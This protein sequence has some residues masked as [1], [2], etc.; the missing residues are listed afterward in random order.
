MKND[1]ASFD[2]IFEKRK[3][4]KTVVTSMT[5]LGVERLKLEKEI[6]L[7]ECNCPHSFDTPNPTKKAEK[8][9]GDFYKTCV[10]CGQVIYG[11]N[12]IVF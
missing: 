5:R 2:N 1:N 10:N 4:Y 8:H 12:R 3:R 7:V 6:N 9:L 11:K